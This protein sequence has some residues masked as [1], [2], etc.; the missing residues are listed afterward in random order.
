MPDF[1]TIR[2]KITERIARIEL[3]HPPANII[4]FELMQEFLEAIDSARTCDILMISSSLPNF[5]SGVDIKIHAPESMHSMLQNFHS[6]VRKLYHFPGLT[7]CVLNGYALGGGVEL[8][9]VCDFILAHRDTQLAFPEI[10]LACFPPVAAILLPRYIGR[11]GY[12]LLYSGEAIS[13][14]EAKSAGMIDQIFSNNT[15]QEITAFLN[16]IGSYSLNALRTLKQCF[17][18]TQTFD[19]DAELTKAEELYLSEIK[20]HPDTREGI[21]A[22][23]QKR[24]PRYRS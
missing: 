12:T 23:L 4:D 7:A 17:R 14:S 24:K 11:K 5:S 15:E 8:A 16:T 2:L 22:F 21:E 18:S 3:N 19:F 6:L 9:L 13:A 10:T 1:R 20:N